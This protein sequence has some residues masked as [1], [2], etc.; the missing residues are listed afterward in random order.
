MSEKSEL[1]RALKALG[2][3]RPQGSEAM[4]ARL[5][6]TDAYKDA[7][8]ILA[9]YGV[10]PEPDTLPLIR[11][12]LED[13]KTLCLPKTYGKGLM[14]A[15]KV[16]SLEDMV[17][18]RYNIPEPREDLDIIPREDIDLIIVPSVALDI[19]GYRLGHGAGYYDR[20]LAGYTGR[21]IA[22]GFEDRLLDRVPTDQYD[23]PVGS[24]VTEKRLIHCTDSEE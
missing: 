9:F 13:G 8:T 2:S 19:R 7:K 14:D 20:Y 4:M 1:R 10:E 3:Q 21:T 15:R 12:A 16:T 23:L 22:P 24:I 18:G 5:L 11:Q 6:D 17:M